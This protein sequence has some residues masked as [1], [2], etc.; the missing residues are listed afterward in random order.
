MAVSVGLGP[1]TDGGLGTAPAGGLG[2]GADG[3]LTAAAGELSALVAGVLAAKAV[4]V[5]MGVVAETGAV[6]PAAGFSERAV[7]AIIA[8]SATSAS[9]SAAS[10]AIAKITR[11]GGPDGS[12]ARHC[13]QKP[14][15]GCV[16]YP[17][18]R[19]R[20]VRWEEPET[21]RVATGDCVH[22]LC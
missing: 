3:E 22:A 8:A 4:L 2:A 20:T 15:T 1:A 11:G 17:Q 13:G 5:A 21:E 14:E 16:V 18:L 10:P 6:L 19:Q 9:Q 7:R 12:R